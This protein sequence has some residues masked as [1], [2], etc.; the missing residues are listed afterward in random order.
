M[1]WNF[2]AKKNVPLK[3]TNDKT[4]FLTSVNQNFRH[5][6]T[7]T[8]HLI[9]VACYFVKLEQDV[10]GNTWEPA[11]CTVFPKHTC[12]R[13]SVFLQVHRDPLCTDAVLDIS[14]LVSVPKIST[15]FQISRTWI[16][17]GQILTLHNPLLYFQCLRNPPTETNG[18]GEV[19][20]GET[21]H[22]STNVS[23]GLE[24]LMSSGPAS[25]VP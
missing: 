3:V 5:R 2:G 20:L 17:F 19:S 10:P 23:C 11:A 1:K 22:L 12:W 8:I 24:T 15:T 25:S 6:V 9:C 18:F 21:G 16:F 7:K 13:L 14:L 4:L